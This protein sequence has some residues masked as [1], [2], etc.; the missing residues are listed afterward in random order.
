[1]VPKV[2]LKALAGD[3]GTVTVLGESPPMH[4]TGGNGR[5]PGRQE[6]PLPLP[7]DRRGKPPPNGPEKIYLEPSDLDALVGRLKFDPDE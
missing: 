3:R 1:L 5:Q 2:D 6:Q 7:F 4:G